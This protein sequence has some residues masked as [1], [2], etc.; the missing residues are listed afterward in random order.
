MS[1]ALSVFVDI[2]DAA[3]TGSGRSVVKSETDM[4]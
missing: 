3:L 1:T 4:G 2:H